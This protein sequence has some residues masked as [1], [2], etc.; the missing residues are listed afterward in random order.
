MSVDFRKF[1]FEATVLLAAYCI[2]FEYAF[3]F[4]TKHVLSDYFSS[5]GFAG[6]RVFLFVKYLISLIPFYISLLLQSKIQPQLRP[7]ALTI[8]T[9]ALSIIVAGFVANDSRLFGSKELV[10]IYLSQLL[11]STILYLGLK[12][13]LHN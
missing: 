5:H 7:L 8:I 11:E 3:I 2:L 12:M 9:F 6:F 10:L 1:T 4:I 13:A